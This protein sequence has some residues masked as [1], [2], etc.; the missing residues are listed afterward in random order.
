MIAIESRYHL[1]CLVDL[2]NKHRRFTSEKHHGTDESYQMECIIFS[3]LVAYI[4][5][6]LLGETVPIFKL[7]DL[8]KLH[9]ECLLQVG[10][11]GRVHST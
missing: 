4:E 7:S 11:V 3:E 9:N 1:Q 2:Y 6:Q 5:E 8:A 10:I